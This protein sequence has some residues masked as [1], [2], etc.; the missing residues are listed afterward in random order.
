MFDTDPLAVLV[1]AIYVVFPIVCG[2]LVVR[3]IRPVPPLKRRPSMPPVGA[4]AGTGVERGPRRSA[5]ADLAALPRSPQTPAGTADPRPGVPAGL[6][7][8]AGVAIPQ[9]PPATPAGV[10]PR[11]VVVHG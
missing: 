1:V 11:R 3:F 4:A 2:W 8:P 5:V 9:N 10:Q 6:Q 7:L